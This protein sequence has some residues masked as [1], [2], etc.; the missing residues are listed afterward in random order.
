MNLEE[1]KNEFEWFLN[2][3]Y[4]DID[5]LKDKI[6]E[7]CNNFCF[8]DLYDETKV[9]ELFDKDLESKEKYYK[10]SYG[11]NSKDNKDGDDT[12]LARIGYFLIHND[13][14]ENN[15]FKFISPRLTVVFVVFKPP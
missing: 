1:C 6:K 4:N 10:L 2:V 12:T 13:S 14:N 15:C 9:N 3:Q 8:D 11:S 7:F 5:N